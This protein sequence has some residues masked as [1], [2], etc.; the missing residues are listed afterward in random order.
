ML[1]AMSRAFEG[2]LEQALQLPEKERSELATRLLLS[3]EPH[4]ADEPTPQEWEAAWSTELDHRI[5]QIREGAVEL[6]DGDD[7]L[8]RLREIADRP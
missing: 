6:V 5:R 2:L 4:A 8:A 7:V 1:F 3:L